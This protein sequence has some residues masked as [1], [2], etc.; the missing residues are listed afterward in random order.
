MLLLPISKLFLPNELQIETKKWIELDVTIKNNINGCLF[1]LATDQNFSVLFKK[2]VEYSRTK[3]I[4][5]EI[6]ISNVW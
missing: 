5:F 4:L 6:G 1:Q 3:S 2:N